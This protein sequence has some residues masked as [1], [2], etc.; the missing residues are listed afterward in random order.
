MHHSHKGTIEKFKKYNKWTTV[1]Y[2]FEFWLYGGECKVRIILYLNGRL[3]KNLSTVTST[4]Q[5]IL[6]RCYNIRYLHTIIISSLYQLKRWILI[7]FKS[8]E[9][10][11]RWKT[12][13]VLFR[14][15]DVPSS[16]GH[17]RTATSYDRP[18]K[19][20][21]HP[22]NNKRRP[23]GRRRRQRSPSAVQRNAICPF[24]PGVV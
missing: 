2:W 19:P 18:A 7:L 1:S 3:K 5:K 16:Y 9:K 6:A 10:R 20:P 12:T 23:G 8:K 4:S 22:T 14:A 11:E 21:Q 15:S 24:C 17:R 13:E